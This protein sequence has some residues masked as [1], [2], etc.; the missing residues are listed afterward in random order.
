MYLASYLRKHGLES[1]IIEL[2]VFK[3]EDVIQQKDRIRFGISDEKIRSFLKRE[4]P[5]IVGITSMYSIYYRDVMELAK[6]VKKFDPKIKVVIGGNHP[7]SYWKFVLKDKNID[8]VVIGE[9]EEIF[10]ELCQAILA[11]QKSFDTIDGLAFRKGKEIIKTSF[12][13]LIK[14]LDGIP[15][16]ARDMIDFKKYLQNSKSMYTM[17][18]PCASI[19][20]SRGCPQDCVYC[21]VKAVWTRSWRGRSAKNVVDEAEILVKQYGVG[22]I[23]LLDDSA[24]VNK[25]RW[26][27]ICDEII[28]RKLDFRWTTPNG[29]A[30]WTLDKRCIRKMKQAGCYRITFGIESGNVETRKFLGKPFP[31]KE[32]EKLIK[33]ANSVGMWTI[34]TNIVGFPYEKMDS[35]R[36]TINFAKKCGTDFAPFYLLIPQPT[37]DVYDYFRKEKLL[38]LDHFFEDLKVNGDEFEEINYVLNETGTDTTYFTKDELRTIQKKAYQEFM[39]YRML[40]YILNPMNILQKIRSWEDFKY[41]VKLL[42]NGFTIFKRTLLPSNIRSGDYL[43]KKPVLLN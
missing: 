32:A 36:D 20:T 22:E 25:K 15:F 43:Y 23:A 37:S 41:T 14:D 13:T 4:R 38:N 28:K 21:T 5:K 11:K 33:Y 39:T 8:F 40:T 2:G 18:N 31:L 24:S 42:T 27:E 12:K 10:L 7:S 17:R 3:I 9:G 16:P 29:I 34:C 26:I 35:I 19:I 6:T 1:K 30:H